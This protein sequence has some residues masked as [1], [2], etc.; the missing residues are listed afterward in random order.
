MSEQPRAFTGVLLLTVLSA[1][2]SG[3]KP[4]PV[5]SPPEASTPASP[6]T[7]PNAAGPSTLVLSHLRLR[8]DEQKHHLLISYALNNRGSSRARAA[9]CVDLIDKEGYLIYLPD[10]VEYINL[11]PGDSDTVE[12]IEL[13]AP[14]DGWKAAESLRFY[15]SDT[16]CTFDDTHVRGEV[17]FLDKSG[18]PLPPGARPEVKKSE[19]STSAFTGPHFRLSDVRVTQNEQKAVEVSYVATN[20]T[21]GRVSG[22]LCARLLEDEHC[23]CQPLDEGAVEWELNLGRGDSERRTDTL[24]LDD[25]AHWGRARRLQFYL[26]RFGCSSPLEDATSNVVSLEKPRGPPASSHSPGG[27]PGPSQER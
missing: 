7:L 12:D 6:P 23:T 22:R 19:A 24:K 20:L 1:L 21:Q 10:R 27:P 4:T 9:L 18:Q 5:S 17:F 13:L 26:S 16:A 11:G 3:C 15:V 8:Y 25:T 14:R 2:H